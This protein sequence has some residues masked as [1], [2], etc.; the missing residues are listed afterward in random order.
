MSKKR[1]LRGVIRFFALCFLAYILTAISRTT[2]KDIPDWQELAA[3]LRR[4]LLTLVCWMEVEREREL[5]LLILKRE[6]D[7]YALIT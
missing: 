3:E 5:L 7:N 2:L 6:S 1:T 4:E